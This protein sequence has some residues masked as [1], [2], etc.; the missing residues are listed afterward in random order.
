MRERGGKNPTGGRDTGQDCQPYQYC[1]TTSPPCVHFEAAS[2]FRQPPVSVEVQH[3]GEVPLGVSV[4]HA[5]PGAV[6]VRVGFVVATDRVPENGIKERGQGTGE[7]VMRYRC[8]ERESGTRQGCGCLSG[9][10]SSHRLGT[11]EASK[12]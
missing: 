7:R 11:C 3:E 4:L 8:G 5:G 12:K 1:Q 10:C 6:A 2:V 9:S